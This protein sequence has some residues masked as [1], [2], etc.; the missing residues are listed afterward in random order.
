MNSLQGRFKGGPG[1]PAWPHGTGSLL[2]G[3]AQRHPAARL[4]LQIEDAPFRIQSAIEQNESAL[5]RI[6]DAP[7][8]ID[9]ALGTDE[10]ALGQ[11]DLATGQIES[12]LGTGQSAAGQIE[13]AA[14]QIECALGT[15]G[16]FLVTN[17][18]GPGSR[19]HAL[20]ST[21]PS[22]GRWI[23]RPARWRHRP[24]DILYGSLHIVRAP[25]IPQLGAAWADMPQS[26]LRQT[27]DRIR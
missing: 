12:F 11:I 17:G 10:S 26:R 14:E 24:D 6:D 22:A 13:L 21:A 4:T 3:L 5:V 20:H 7:E 1:D 2:G 9:S 23:N 27:D 25:A 18:S 16:P 15:D 19:P 8:Q